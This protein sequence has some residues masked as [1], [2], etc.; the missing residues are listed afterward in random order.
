M[1]RS[2]FVFLAPFAALVLV[3]CGIVSFF[4]IFFTL[5]PAPCSP[6]T[7]IRSVASWAV[8][9]SFAISAIISV[10]LMFR[11]GLW[12]GAVAL[13]LPISAGGAYAASTPFEA[14]RQTKC[15]AQSWREAMV[16]CQADPSNYRL[17]KDGY[18]NPTLTLHPPGDTD[19]SWSCLSD[20]ALHN[21]KYS[22][23]IDESV[24]VLAR[25][26][27]DRARSASTQSSS[28]TAE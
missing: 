24:Y 3:L 1:N 19:R 5:A 12:T 10:V 4:L 11:G 8:P 20:R 14:A 17:G 2:G 6:P 21:G 18:G 26:R 16:S 27:Y 23:L 13:L 9:V 25:Q 15:A 22:M 28:S 7:F